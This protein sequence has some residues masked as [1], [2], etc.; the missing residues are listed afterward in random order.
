MAVLSEGITLNKVVTGK[1]RKLL[2]F[3]KLEEELHEEGV[4]KSGYDL[5]SPGMHI[6]SDG[7]TVLSQ[8]PYGVS[9]KI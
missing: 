4:R 2:S 3:Q 5:G 8:F 1:I 6:L 9:G 7:E